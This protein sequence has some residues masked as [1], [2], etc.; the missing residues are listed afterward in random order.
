MRIISLIVVS[1]ILQ[2]FTSASAADIHTSTA[3]TAINNVIQESNPS[4][5]NSIN[6]GGRQASC[7]SVTQNRQWIC[8]VYKNEICNALETKSSKESSTP[9]TEN[10]TSEIRDIY[11]KTTRE[12][13]FCMVNNT[14]TTLKFIK[15]NSN[16]DAYASKGSQFTVASGINRLYIMFSVHAFIRDKD[17]CSTETVS[18][19]FRNPD[20]FKYFERPVQ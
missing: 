1:F 15:F 4:F 10:G 14:P 17:V 20:D 2:F 12:V 7:E 3:C 13:T 5:S 8:T 19:E 11:D 6:I 9:T 16:E 18:L